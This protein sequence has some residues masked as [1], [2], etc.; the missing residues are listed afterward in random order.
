MNRFL[1]IALLVLL[2]SP[3]VVFAQSANDKLIQ[4]IKAYNELEWEAAIRLFNDALQLGLSRTS[5]IAVYKYLGF[6]YIETDRPAMAKKAF[7]D[8]LNMDPD[9]RLD[10]NISPKYLDIFKIVRSE[11][12]PAGERLLQDGVKTYNELDFENAIN[13]LEESLREELSDNLKIEAYKYLAFCYIEDN[14][15]DE[16]KSA[17]RK[18]LAVEADFVLG[19][20]FA[21]KYREIFGQ[22]RAEIEPVARVISVKSVPSGASVYFDSKLQ[23]DRTP[24]VIKNVD[25]GTHTLRISLDGHEDWTG[26]ISKPSWEKPLV[27][28]GKPTLEITA[29]LVKIQPTPQPRA[30]PIEKLKKKTGSI[31]ATSEPSSAQVRLDDVLQKRFTPMTIADVIAG[32]HSLKFALDGYKDWEQTIDVEVEKIAEINAK[33]VP[34]PQ[35]ERRPTP[36]VKR[37]GK[38]KWYLLSGTAVAAGGSVAAFLLS[39]GGG[40]VSSKGGDGGDIPL[41]TASLKISIRV[42]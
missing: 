20:E 26:E 4:G 12:E 38:L 24:M 37:G 23:S 33:L 28:Q 16:A 42:P 11:F 7:E 6:C 39:R 13:R 36:T 40:R 41:E 27:V 5:Q 34:I 9:Y 10:P 19:N 35:P 1:A 32:R 8:I 30:K 22:V 14:Q 3:V 25:T 15:I 17:F 29:A 18:L 2:F 31:H 21:R